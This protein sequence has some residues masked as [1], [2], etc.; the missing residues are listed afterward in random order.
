M[1]SY[2]S[3]TSIGY[4]HKDPSLRGDHRV[5]NYEKKRNTMNHQ[6][7][8]NYPSK[9]WENRFEKASQEYNN[10]YQ[11]YINSLNIEL[12]DEDLDFDNEFE[13]K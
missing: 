10:Q 5:G 11:E 13:H 8:Q 12:G 2:R 7:S 6:H 3:Q 9:M 1:G 4:Q